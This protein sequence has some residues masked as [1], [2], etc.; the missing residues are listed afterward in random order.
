MVFRGLSYP[1][2]ARTHPVSSVFLV[3]HTPLLLVV[4]VVVVVVVSKEHR[5]MPKELGI[6]GC[7]P[8]PPLQFVVFMLDYV[9]AM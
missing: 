6:R 9:C 1:P 3:A 4:V 7:C 8:P 5:K 2:A